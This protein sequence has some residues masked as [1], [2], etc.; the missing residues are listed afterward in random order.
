[1]GGI[2]CKLFR[3]RQMRVLLNG[4]DAAG[5]TTILYQLR[6]G[7]VVT[8]IPTIG[9]NVE[10]VEYK[11]VQ[12]V[13]WDVGG[14][15]KM[16]PLFRHYY[17]GT[18]AVV[19]VVDSND[20]ERTEQAQKELHAIIKEDSVKEVIIVIMA[21]KQDLPGS[22]TPEEVHEKLDVDSI[23]K[24]HTCK[25]FGT[26]A[27]TGEGLYDMLDWLVEAVNTKQA[28]AIL[29]GKD[30]CVTVE[31]DSKSSYFTTPLSYIKHMF[32]KV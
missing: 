31:K 30:E 27:T 21:N 24:T 5:K 1:M 17:P 4:L 20:K 22:M 23:C 26:S 29:R 16:R 11:N 25:V 6:L 12:L 28:T 2:F 9:F 8:T 7:E 15:D 10:T 13:T 14:R 32:S 18:D 3:K 19:F